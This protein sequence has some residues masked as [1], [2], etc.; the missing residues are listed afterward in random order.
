MIA[1]STA[2]NTKPQTTPSTSLDITAS[3]TSP[4]NL[5]SS[6]ANHGRCCPD[7]SIQIV[8]FAPERLAYKLVLFS[9]CGQRWDW[10]Q[11]TALTVNAQ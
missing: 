2:P 9:G 1:M 8:L 7:I 3:L 4:W 11:I 5:G 10:Q 6:K